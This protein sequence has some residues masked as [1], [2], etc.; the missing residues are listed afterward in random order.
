MVHWCNGDFQYI[1]LTF[2]FIFFFLSFKKYIF[3]SFWILS[4]GQFTFY[5]ALQMI[6]VC[7]YI[8]GSKWIRSTV[9]LI[10]FHLISSL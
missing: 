5:T 8:D 10:I 2:E 4:V 3:L 7:L 6:F 9:L 1:M